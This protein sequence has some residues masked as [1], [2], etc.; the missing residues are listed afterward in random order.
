[1]NRPTKCAICQTFGESREIYE[2]TVDLNSFTSEIFSAR[3]LPDR[4]HYR[5]VMCSR[6]KLFR[7][8][9]VSDI[10]L[11]ELYKTSTFDYSTELHGL[12]NSYRKIVLKI[13]Q[14]T[15]EKSIVEIGGGNGFFLQEALEMGFTKLIE[16]EPSL[17]AFES[18]HETLKPYFIVDMLRDGLIPDNSIDVVVMFHV[19]DHVPDPSLVLNQIY[20]MLKPGGSICIAVHNVNSVSAKILK[21]KSPIFDV[22][23]TYLYSKK[24]IK[25]LLN[26]SDFNSIKVHHY[27]NSYSLAYLV[28]LIPINR[29]IKIKILNSK[30]GEWL[31]SIRI[32]VPLGNMWAAGYK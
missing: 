3:R 26:Q 29:N 16:I 24:T 1:M 23:H 18:A 9:P 6:C 31:R 8:D 10:D 28:H 27:K 2:S 22:E 30:F 17:S 21:N 15:K 4:K 5:W 12:R 20:K 25:K 32:T 11:G 7:S 14:S 19:L 13:C